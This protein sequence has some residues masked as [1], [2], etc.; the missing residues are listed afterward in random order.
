MLRGGMHAPSGRAAPS[1][2]ADAHVRA[3]RPATARRRSTGRRRA[4][5]P[6]RIIR[7]TSWRHKHPGPNASARGNTAGPADRRPPAQGARRAAPRRAGGQRPGGRGQRPGSGASRCG[8]TR[9]GGSR[10]KHMKC[11]GPPAARRA[12]RSGSR[13]SLRT[14]LRLCTAEVL[15]GS[16]AGIGVFPNSAYLQRWERTRSSPQPLTWRNPRSAMPNAR[17]GRHP[18][19]QNLPT[20]PTDRA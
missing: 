14:N 5:R 16:S 17:S 1:R 7:G 6:P 3:G 20:L 12:P 19:P 15:V 8:A 4:S 10:G 11:A 13:C 2:I 18:L 9:G